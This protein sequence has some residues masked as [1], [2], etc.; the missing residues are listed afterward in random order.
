MAMLKFYNKQFKINEANILRD[1]AINNLTFDY[2]Q[3]KYVLFE[4]HVTEY[5]L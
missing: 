1:R 5:D 4:L 2:M 3:M